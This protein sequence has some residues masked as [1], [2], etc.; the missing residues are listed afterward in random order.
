MKKTKSTTVTIYLA[1]HAFENRYL[2]CWYSIS[3]PGKRTIQFRSDEFVP[4]EVEKKL[5]KLHCTIGNPDKLMKYCMPL[6]NPYLTKVAERAVEY[7]KKY[8][9]PKPDSGDFEFGST[10]NLEDQFQETEP[11]RIRRRKQKTT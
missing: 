6:L 2:M 3:I 8:P 7:F 11:E 10:G 9:E 4:P 5:H 1:S